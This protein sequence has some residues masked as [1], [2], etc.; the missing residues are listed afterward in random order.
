MNARPDS[1]HALAGD[2]RRVAAPLA[3]IAVDMHGTMAPLAE[4]NA[5]IGAAV[6]SLPRVCAPPDAVAAVAHVRS[7]AAVVART[8]RSAAAP[9]TAP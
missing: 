2:L 6:A 4:S 5:A 9:G 3:A 1:L 8:L 7:I